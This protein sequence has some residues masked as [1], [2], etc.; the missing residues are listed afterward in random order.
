MLELHG[1]PLIEILRVQ[2]TSTQTPVLTRFLR[3]QA[4]PSG[5]RS[6]TKIMLYKNCMVKNY[7][8]GFIQ[9]LNL[10]SK[11]QSKLI[12]T[13]N[14]SIYDVIKLQLEDAS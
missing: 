9:L 8:P 6:T 12:L 4:R 5:Y 2:T 7:S 1:K 10:V 13:F 14:F 11:L 3:D